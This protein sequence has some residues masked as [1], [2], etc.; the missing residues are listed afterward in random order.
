MRKL[1]DIIFTLRDLIALREEENTGLE[2]RI[3]N[4]EGWLKVGEEGK[5]EMMKTLRYERRE[6]RVLVADAKRVRRELGVRI[7]EIKAKW[8]EEVEGLAERKRESEMVSGAVVSFLLW[9]AM[10]VGKI[11]DF[12]IGYVVDGVFK[13]TGLSM[14]VVA[15]VLVYCTWWPT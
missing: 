1:K 6:R 5:R 15:L 3:K 10:G 11:G 13:A 14:V 9:V 7:E 2:A 4:L 12:A 8:E